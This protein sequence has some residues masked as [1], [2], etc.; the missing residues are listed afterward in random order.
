[1]QLKQTHVHFPSLL[2]EFMLKL[3]KYSV[4]FITLGNLITVFFTLLLTYQIHECWNA[5]NLIYSESIILPSDQKR[6]WTGLKPL[7]TIKIKIDWDWLRRVLCTQRSRTTQGDILYP[8]HGRVR[9]PFTKPLD[10]PNSLDTT[11]RAPRSKTVPFT[12]TFVRSLKKGIF[13]H[14]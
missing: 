1:M 4:N 6:T 2:F 10:W 11:R 8:K 14:E 12:T 3:N 7:N 5:S 13:M 9:P